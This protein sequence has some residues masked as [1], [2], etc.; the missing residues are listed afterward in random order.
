MTSEKTN[1]TALWRYIRYMNGIQTDG[2][3]FSHPL[4]H[5]GKSESDLPFICLD[6]FAH[7]YVYPGSIDTGLTRLSMHTI[8]LHSVLH[9][10]WAIGSWFVG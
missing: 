6:S 9:F 10:C 7:M 8:R 2:V 5:L 4:A 3:T 1:G